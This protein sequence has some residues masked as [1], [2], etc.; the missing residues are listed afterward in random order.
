MSAGSGECGNTSLDTSGG[1]R[2][3]ALAQG[4][5]GPHVDTHGHDWEPP[6]VVLK[7]LQDRWGATHRIVWTG[8]MWVATAHR[9]D[10]P[11]RTEI[12]PTPQ[13]LEARLRSRPLLPH[14]R[15]GT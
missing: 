4:H 6:E 5:T 13:Q 3:C 2:T 7:R 1:V 10:V 11:W 12:E 15:K 8:R 9:A 14:P